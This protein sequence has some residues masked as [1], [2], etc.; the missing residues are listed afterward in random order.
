MIVLDASSS[1]LNDDAPGLRID[2]A[3]DAAI[4]L[5]ETLP[6]DAVVGL[7]AYGTGTGDSDAEEAAGC[8]DIKT[9]VPVG[10][11]DREALVSQISEI[12]AS[13]YT[14]IGNALRAAADELPADGERA[15]VLVSDGIDVCAPPSPCDVAKELANEGV[16]LTIHTVG[17]KVDADAR[18]DLQCIADATGGTYADASDAA[19]LE[20]TLETKVTYAITGYDV[21][22][23]PIR[24]VEDPNSPDL[25][26]LHPGQWTDTID[27]SD[28][29]SADSETTIYYALEEREG[30][31]QYVAVTA[32]YPTGVTLDGS[33]AHLRATVLSA[34]G[35]ACGE[36][37]DTRT[38]ATDSTTPLTISIAANCDDPALLQVDFSQ[39]LFPPDM[40]I[41][42]LSRLEPPA[43]ASGV[44]AP[45]ERAVE[46]PTARSETVE[47][48]GAPSFNGAVEI[49]PGQTY[50]GQVLTGETRYYKVPVE[51]G[52]QLSALAVPA[53]DG[54]TTGVAVEVWDPMRS[55]LLRD[56]QVWDDADAT[57]LEVA[58]PEVVRYTSDTYHLDGFYYVTVA[59][60]GAGEPVPWEFELTVDT[61]GDVEAGP[62]YDLPTPTPVATQGAQDP[63]APAPSD[64]ATASPENDSGASSAVPWIAGGSVVV[65]GAGAGAWYVLS[66][67]RGRA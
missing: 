50:R 22:G 26:T 65:L 38:F 57:P 63:D 23:T 16:D 58:T 13:G 67:R 48:D 47:L 25:A 20:S 42:I 27:L 14:P 4:R 12:E 53:A 54:P 9:L 66:R 5:V 40:D 24:A 28:H 45:E 43:D 7:Q 39:E 49:T 60:N 64:S 59:A 36:A 1:M 56:Y 18:A 30:W 29:S 62:V 3:K 61:P 46:A 2:A 52:Q 41:E 55:A 37:T 34:E 32:V 17:F 31:T 21:E 44:P 8:K 51:W 6:S 10:P 35:S 33:S 19:Q 11:L 15:I